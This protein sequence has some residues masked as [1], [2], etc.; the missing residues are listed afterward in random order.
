MCL[1]GTINIAC[2]FKG[3]ARQQHGVLSYYL[4]GEGEGG[5]GGKERGGEREVGGVG[6]EL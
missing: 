3:E 2:M 4:R 1:D 5:G 6:V